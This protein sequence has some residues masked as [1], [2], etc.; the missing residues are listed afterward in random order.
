MTSTG[1][2]PSTTRPSSPDDSSKRYLDMTVLY[3]VRTGKRKQVLEQQVISLS[4]SPLPLSVA[5]T[6]PN[7]TT[8]ST[9]ADRAVNA[10]SNITSPSR[11]AGPRTAALAKFS[12]VQFHLRNCDVYTGRT[13]R[14]ARSMS[15]TCMRELARDRSYSCRLSN[16]SGEKEL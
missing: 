15:G 2:R 16:H 4:H 1:L 11:E 3:L 13:S 5:F 6:S 9:T 7:T 12:T 8:V 10:A 14:F